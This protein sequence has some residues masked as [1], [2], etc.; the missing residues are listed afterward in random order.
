MKQYLDLLQYILDHGIKKPTRAK[1]QSTGK[2]VSAISVFGYQMRFNLADGFPAITTKKLGFNA[3]VHELIWFLSGD[4]NI[5][6]L[7]DNGVKIW[8]EW[9]NA[10][11]D[12]GPVY[13]YQW[14]RWGGYLDQVTQL[15]ADIETVKHN[16]T[17]SCG[18]RLILTAWNP[19]DISK[20][21]LP[22]CHLMCQ[23]MVTEGRLSCHMYQR[24]ADVFLGV[25]FNI[26]SYALLTHLLA[27]FTGLGV[28][29]FIH[30]FGDVHIY[31]NHVPQVLEQLKR[32]PALLPTLHLNDKLTRLEN[33]RFEDIKLINYLHHAAL[34]AE[35]AV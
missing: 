25:P 20:M 32:E 24:S 27:R 34:K 5:K 9:A 17:A 2:H 11:G 31:E 35:V 15:L 28:G 21:A 19:S 6:Y 3:I 29:D 22:P 1:L 10:S 18:R 23:F 7:Q 30:T 4:T 14:R 13:G 26:A 16:P 8:D 33:L 12:L